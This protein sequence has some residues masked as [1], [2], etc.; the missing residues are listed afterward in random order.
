MKAFWKFLLRKNLPTDS[1]S[2]L[3]FGVIGLGDSSY[4]K[5]NFVAKKLHKRL[6]QLGGK[7]ILNVALCDDQHDLGIGAVLS[8]WLEEFWRKYPLPSN[9]SP[10]PM[11]T[12]RWMVNQVDPI[13]DKDL[14][15]YAD[16]EESFSDA[17]EQVLVN[18]SYFINKLEINIYIFSFLQNNKRTTSK[19]H[20][21]DVRLISFSC[22]KLR[23]NVGDVAYIRPRNSSESVSQL[24]AILKE[25][26]LDWENV[27]VML[28]GDDGKKCFT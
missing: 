19:D 2:C 11:R 6:I 20:F 5:F 4:Q 7:A 3:I 12:T 21:Q 23:W 17:F 15:I 22:H 18:Y 26:G 28:K 10:L 13:D 27:C 14:D 1:L 9:L 8:P 16:F 25:H 24:F